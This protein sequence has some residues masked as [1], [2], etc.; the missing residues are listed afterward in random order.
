MQDYV[1]LI[2]LQVSC[3]YKMM[4]SLRFNVLKLIYMIIYSTRILINVFFKGAKSND[5]LPGNYVLS[6]LTFKKPETKKRASCS[7][8]QYER[9]Q[10]HE[11]VKNWFSHKVNLFLYNFYFLF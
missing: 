3:S 11:K 5:P 2:L 10:K 1:V 8:E 4:F 7:T 9:Q 6:V